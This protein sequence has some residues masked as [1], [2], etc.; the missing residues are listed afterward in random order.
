MGRERVS[1]TLRVIWRLKLRLNRHEA[2]ESA[3][4]DISNLRFKLRFNSICFS[5]PLS[6]FFSVVHQYRVPVNRLPPPRQCRA[7]TRN[8][9]SLIVYGCLLGIAHRRTGG[10]DRPP[11]SLAHRWTGNLCSTAVIARSSLYREPLLVRRHPRRD[12]PAVAHPRF[13][14]RALTRLVCCFTSIVTTHVLIVRL[15]QPSLHTGDMFVLR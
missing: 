15:R 2:C 13:H 11:P 9:W 10:P 5:R 6:F 14:I 12:I 1:H 7:P 3:C 8:P 4:R